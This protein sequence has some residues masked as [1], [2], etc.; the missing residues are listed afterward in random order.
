M[1]SR[2]F[3]HSK[4]ELLRVIVRLEF[5]NVTLYINSGF[6]HLERHEKKSYWSHIH[7]IGAISQVLH[8]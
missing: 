4:S 5:G 6:S 3:K 8:L 7:Y 2:T 1:R